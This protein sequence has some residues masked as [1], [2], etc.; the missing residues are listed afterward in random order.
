MSHVLPEST[1]AFF[2]TIK[3]YYYLF[4]NSLYNYLIKFKEDRL[5]NYITL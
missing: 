3:K 5:L 1:T 2:I 4:Y